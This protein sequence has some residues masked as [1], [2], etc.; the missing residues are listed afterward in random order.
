MDEDEELQLREAELLGEGTR[1]AEGAVLSKP[2]KYILRLNQ[3]WRTEIASPEILPYPKIIGHDGE[4]SL[5]EMLKG[6]LDIQV[7]GVDSMRAGTTEDG[8]ADNMFAVLIYDMDIE[9]VRF[10]LARLLRARLVKIEAQ[11][12]AIAADERLQQ[13]LSPQ[14]LDVLTGLL[15]LHD[16]HFAGTVLRQPL[17][18]SAQDFIEKESAK[19]L[20]EH[21]RANLDQFVVCKPE[22]SFTARNGNFTE[23]EVCITNYKYIS[24]QVVMNQAILL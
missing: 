9:R 18:K 13:R 7:E 4:K 17:D 21:C 6:M 24:D 22:E 10:A 11:L 19:F 15:E 14:E 23:G 1:E 2:N 3:I 5:V 8:A 20:E 16:H 12:F